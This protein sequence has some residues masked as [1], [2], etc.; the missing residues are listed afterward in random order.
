V[1]FHNGNLILNGV[2][3]SSIFCGDVVTAKGPG[4][5]FLETLPNGA[6]LLI[7]RLDPGNVLFDDVSLTVP[8]DSYF[9]LGDN[10]DQSSDSRV[11]GVVPSQKII[12]RAALIYWSADWRR[13]GHSLAIR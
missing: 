13:I 6:K 4:K 9:V 7:Q 11:F 5:Q 8:P 10:R 3:I 1:A 12:G 2:P